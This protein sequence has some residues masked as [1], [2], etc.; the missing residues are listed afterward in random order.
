MPFAYSRT[1]TSIPCLAVVLW[2]ASCVLNF[3]PAT[4]VNAQD[5]VVHIP[6]PPK[7]SPLIFYTLGPPDL[8]FADALQIARRSTLSLSPVQHV[9]GETNEPGT[10]RHSV[11]FLDSS[12]RVRMAYLRDRGRL[13]WL[14]DL[15]PLKR[16]APSVSASINLAHDWIRSTGIFKQPMDWTVGGT[17]T[18]S[19]QIYYRDGTRLPAVQALRTVHFHREIDGCR[20]KARTRSWQFMSEVRVLSGFP[21]S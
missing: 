15:G 7:S 2:T 11:R 13:E 18:L 6:S 10:G 12:N 19:R 9:D 8:S 16:D 1:T 4:P 5:V 3:L 14:P 17:T 20:W 21:T